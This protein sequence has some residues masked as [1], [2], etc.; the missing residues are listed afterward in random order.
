[1]A[2]II[3]TDYNFKKIITDEFFKKKITGDYIIEFHRDFNKI[4][5]LLS[6]ITILLFGVTMLL[7]GGMVL[8]SKIYYV[9]RWGHCV[10]I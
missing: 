7:S 4:T 2:Y 6:R 3:V 9:T 8:L 10:N 1:M 5:V